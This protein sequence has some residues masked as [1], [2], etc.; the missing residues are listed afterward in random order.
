MTKENSLVFD[1]GPIISLTTNNLLG[2]LDKLKDDFKGQFYIP[3]VVKEEL[4]DHPLN[5]KKYKF[6]ALQVNHKIKKGTLTVV[7]TPQIR[8]LAE[9]LKNMLNN[10]FKVRGSWLQIVHYGEME[11]LAVAI[12]LNA[13]AVVI[14]ERTTR[15]MIEDPD[16]FSRMLE[17]K[18]RAKV[19]I[20]EQNLKKFKDWVKGIKIIRS[21][22]LVTVAYEKGH[23]D[24]YLLD[25]PDAKRVLIESLL[26]GVK[27][28]GCS[29]TREEISEIVSAEQ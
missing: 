18:M 15:I 5:T 8:A 26:W 4:I 24:K 16:G 17:S 19:Q 29:V 12:I 2:V 9:E 14:D 1:A 25:G 27:L 21:V 22:E 28:H 23:F 7:D 3:Q 20:N 11:A 13:G 6:E 10:A